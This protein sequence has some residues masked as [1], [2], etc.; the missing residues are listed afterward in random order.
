[1]KSTEAQRYRA[2]LFAAELGL[3][4][5]DVMPLVL[6]GAPCVRELDG[7]SAA[8]IR[9]LPGVGVERHAR[10]LRAIRG[11]GIYLPDD[12]YPQ[13]LPSALRCVR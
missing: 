2:G 5:R 4:W 10:L 3:S 12:G 1:M 8:D 11:R 13:D 7:W 9:A 6:G